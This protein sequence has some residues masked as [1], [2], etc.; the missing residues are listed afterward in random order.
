MRLS[1]PMVKVRT[2]FAVGSETTALRA[3]NFRSST[4]GRHETRISRN[5]R[6]DSCRKRQR[7]GE[8]CLGMR[9]ILSSGSREEI[10]VD[11]LGI[12]ISGKIH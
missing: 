1:R 8:F 10:P 7:S 5:N 4:I 12:R 3:H 11:P 9:A 6:Y 2:R